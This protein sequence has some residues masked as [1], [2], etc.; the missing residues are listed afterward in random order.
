MSDMGKILSQVAKLDGE[1]YTTWSESCM[2]MLEAYGYDNILTGQGP[3]D[4][5]SETGT[6]DKCLRAILLM[7]MNECTRDALK[8]HNTAP[9]V[10][11]AAKKKFGTPSRMIVAQLKKE[12]YGDILEGQGIQLF[13]NK[14]KELMM[15][16][17]NA[18]QDVSTD[19]VD[20]VLVGV[21]H[22]FESVVENCEQIQGLTLAILE[23][24][25][26]NAEEARSIMAN[27]KLETANRV[28]A[29][30]DLTCQK[31]GKA[32][33]QVQQCWQ[34]KVC[35]FCKKV[36]HL[37]KRCFQRR[38]ADRAQ[39][40]ELEDEINTSFHVSTYNRFT[41]LRNEP[42]IIAD[43]GAS[44][45]MT[46]K[47]SNFKT[48]RRMSNRQKIKV[49]NGDLIDVAGKGIKRFPFLIPMHAETLHAPR[50]GD[51]TLFSISAAVK[52]GNL[53]KFDE[54][55]CT[56]CDNQGNIV[57]TGRLKN[58]VY[59]MN[60]TCDQEI[61]QTASLKSNNK[62]KLWHYRLGHRNEPD[63]I[64]M[65]NTGIVTGMNIEGAYAKTPCHDCALFKAAKRSFPKVRAEQAHD[66]FEVFHSDLCGPLPVPSLQGA[67]HFVTY[68]DSKSKYRVTKLLLQKNHQ[69]EIFKQLQAWSERQVGRKLKMLRADNG[70]EFL[71][72]SFQRY[73]SQQ[74][75]EFQSTIA[76]CSAQNGLVERSHYTLLNMARTMLGHANLPGKFWGTA[77]IY[78]TNILNMLPHPNDHSITPYEMVH[79][80]KPSVKMFKVFG[81]DAYAMPRKPGNKLS[82]RSGL[83]IFVGMADSQK[84]WKLYDP[85]TNKTNTFYHVAFHEMSFEC[86][87]RL[88]A[89][90][91][92][93]NLSWFDL[94]ANVHD[95]TKLAADE[96]PTQN[97]ESANIQDVDV[98]DIR[99]GIQ[100]NVQGGDADVVEEHGNKNSES[101]Q[102]PPRELRRSGRI[103]TK[104]KD[105][106]RVHKDNTGTDNET[107]ALE[108]ANAVGIPIDIKACQIDMPNSFEQA[109]QGP[110][111]EFWRNAAS[112]EFSSLIQQGTW[113]PATL[114]QGRKAIGCKWVFKVK[115]KANGAVDKFKARLV[116]KGFSQRPGID[117]NE[118]FA[119]VAHQVSLRMILALAAQRSLELR[120][121]DVVGAYLNG[122]VDEEI[123]MTLPKEFQ[124]PDEGSVV[125]LCKAL[126]GLKQAGMVWNRAIDCFLTDELGFHRTVADPC[127]YTRNHAPDIMLLAIYVDDILIAHNNSSVANGIVTQI[128][129]KFDITD[130]G[131]P[132]KLLGMRIQ[133]DGI[134]GD[135]VLDQEYYISET[136]DRF[137]MRD[138][139]PA[140][141][142]HGVGHYLTSDMCA[143][144]R[145]EFN[146]MKHTPYKELVGSL[147]YIC[148]MTRPDIAT[149][150]GVLC[151]FAANPGEQHWNAAKRVLRYLSGTRTFGLKYRKSNDGRDDLVGYSDSDWAGDPETRRST[152]GFVFIMANGP[153]SWKSKRQRVVS[154][155]S[156]EAEYVALYGAVREAAWMRTL[157]CELGFAPAKATPIF[158]DNNGCIAI[159]KN[160]RTDERTKHIDVKYHFTR[161]KVE[162][163]DVSIEPCGTAQMI[164]DSLTKPID[165]KKFLWCR[166]AMGVL[167]TSTTGDSLRGRV[168][169]DTLPPD[170]YMRR[171]NAEHRRLRTPDG[172]TEME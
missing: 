145:D 138:C 172:V 26:L 16:L 98:E 1:N 143:V 92:S 84:G 114:P 6:R 139:N 52:G 60:T 5:S 119:P 51:M 77:V 156:V 58:K 164:A 150:V 81:C 151:R 54:H 13:I 18:N 7:S 117:Y 90:F 135:I 134:T 85:S 152:S 40:A 42:E 155:S 96:R 126:Y 47:I 93:D 76:G 38:N 27:A 23:E 62:L 24:R 48:Y 44:N 61:A 161:Q 86:C 70:G 147:N 136:M 129:A 45:H 113:T 102:S 154:T 53:F 107:E 122:T 163:G 133:R 130:L 137:N 111:A 105:F 73:L 19:I 146:H 109:M 74:G 168:E 144:T 37:E 121:L 106:W 71:S 170:A 67:R 171:P 148:T 65:H 165:T 87:K 41:R 127:L 25:L 94:L 160:R 9:D 79:K 83:M 112:K 20:A 132:A 43:S 15:K 80:V 110:Y 95:L 115:A 142:P 141:T 82:N 57:G 29:S 118:T 153:V 88:S 49:A 128:A 17:K 55:G 91:A 66:V 34:N 64:R 30:K 14:K 158:E 32:G 63:L 28:M 36:G 31:C 101:C 68:V 100:E 59:V 169:I 157:L 12:F 167:Q 99:S 89:Q 3:A 125:R 149:A 8:S 39:V 140:D 116:I 104:P 166:Q 4:K 56:L 78:A 120:Q 97:D 72:S 35:T 11:N 21:R 46:G 10:W 123:Y 2:L 159:S 50:L 33:H 69:E 131:Q 162:C 124:K 75:I 103:R 108:L 22:C